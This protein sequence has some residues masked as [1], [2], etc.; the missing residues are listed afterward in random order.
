MKNFITEIS[1]S[2]TQITTITHRRINIDVA[3]V[4]ARLCKFISLN[5]SKLEQDLSDKTV[6][7]FLTEL[8]SI[9]DEMEF[10]TKKFKADQK[11]RRA[12]LIS[13]DKKK[14]SGPVTRLEKKD[15]EKYESN[16]HLTARQHAHFPIY[17]ATPPYT[18]GD[19]PQHVDDYVH[20]LLNALEQAKQAY[21]EIE[22]KVH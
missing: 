3:R 13:P 7:R 14:R 22:K 18:K 16:H 10:L 20:H 21:E 2:P 11:K 12:E 17:V 19:I 5:Q 15:K 1:K 6:V 9:Y 8:Q 4:G